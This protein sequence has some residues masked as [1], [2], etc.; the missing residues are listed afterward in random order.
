MTDVVAG[1]TLTTFLAF[2]GAAVALILTPG[3]DTMYVLARGMQGRSAGVRSALGISTGVLVH[4]AAAALGLAA[5]LRAAPTAY[6]LVKY[7]GALYL[8]YLGLSALRDDEFDPT[9]QTDADGSFRR[10][11]FVNALNPKVALFFLAFLPGFAGSGSGAE[12]RMFLLGGTYAVLTALYLSGVAFASGQMGSMLASSRFS[13][14][15]N[16]LGGGV[17]V[18][19]GVGVAVE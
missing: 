9:V 19:L 7:A 6:R 14:G 3:P 12:L 17:M 11:V 2:C 10:G 5:L 1:L 13:S 16:W 15:L 8:I 4:T 18:A